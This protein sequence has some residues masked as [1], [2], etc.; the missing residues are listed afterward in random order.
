MKAAIRE[1]KE[2]LG[3]DVFQLLKDKFVKDVHE[4]ELVSLGFNP[5]VLTLISILLIKRK[6]SFN[7]SCDEAQSSYW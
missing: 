6:V 4:L 2:E 3:V 1:M 7:V 5:T